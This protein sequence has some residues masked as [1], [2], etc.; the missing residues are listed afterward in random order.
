MLA[1]R[2]IGALALTPALALALGASAQAG[3]GAPV[4]PGGTPSVQAYEWMP[5]GPQAGPQLLIMVKLDVTGK[6]AV[7]CGKKWIFTYFGG[8]P[9]NP[10]VQNAA[11][12]AISGT[13]TFSGA[14][15]G[16]SYLS[17]STDYYLVG[18]AGPLTMSLSAQPSNWPA[19]APLSA[20]GTLKLTLYAPGSTVL[21]ARGA[22]TSKRRHHRRRAK[23]RAT[24]IASC[25]IPFVAPNH[26]AGE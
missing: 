20:T 7:Q 17:A 2:V 13:A 1:R 14:G 21:K 19:R 24:I 12:G 18:S 5:N 10:I 11:T 4:G 8:G 22:A 3:G 15:V 23:R 25:Q 9:A 6:F 26:F 16:S